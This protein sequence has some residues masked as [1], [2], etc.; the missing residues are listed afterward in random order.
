MYLIGNPV[1]V[2]GT[3]T[4][5][6]LWLVTSGLALHFRKSFQ[7]RVKDV[8][9]LQ[10]CGY[11]NLGF[12]MGLGMGFRLVVTCSGLDAFL[13]LT[14]RRAEKWSFALCFGCVFHGPVPP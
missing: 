8:R 6:V 13:L 4:I 2:W 5:I 3:S 10:L 1:V 11:G 12:G 7:Y 14:F 9:G